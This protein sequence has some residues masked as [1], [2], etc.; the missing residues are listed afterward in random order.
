MKRTTS[1]TDTH[2]N[3]ANKREQTLGKQKSQGGLKVS[4]AGQSTGAD[5]GGGGGEQRGATELGG[6]FADRGMVSDLGGGGGDQRGGTE[7]GGGGKPRERSPVS[8]AV[9]K[10]AGKAES[11]QEKV[12][13]GRKRVRRA[14]A[15]TTR[16]RP[17]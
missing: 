4:R 10:V 13:A 6:G 3:N 12:A 8:G 5:L 9:R 15:S 1:G 16:R 14:A 2:H 17:Q 11:P 7:L